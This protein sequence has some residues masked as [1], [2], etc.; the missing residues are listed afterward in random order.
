MADELTVSDP[1]AGA[2]G[3]DR[4]F[5]VVVDGLYFLVILLFTTIAVLAV[6]FAAPL[7]IIA[8]ALAGAVSA[9]SAEGAGRSGWR[10]AG[11]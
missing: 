3:R 4:S 8:T 2:S 1:K 6:A 10:A 5:S 9:A 7:V 11:V